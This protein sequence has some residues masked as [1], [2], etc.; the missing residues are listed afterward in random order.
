MTFIVQQQCSRIGVPYYNCWDMLGRQ[1]QLHCMQQLGL[2]RAVQT[3]IAVVTRYQTN[4][5]TCAYT[6]TSTS[7]S[8][9]IHTHTHTHMH[10][11]HTTRHRHTCTLSGRTPLKQISLNKID[12]SFIKMPHVQIVVRGAD[13]TQLQTLWRPLGMS[14]SLLA[15]STSSSSIICNYT[16][17]LGAWEQNPSLKLP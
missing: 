10:T 2:L 1:T 6:L 15:S 9:H 7:T 17:V 16:H 5:H 8:T 14:G 13:K 11:H 3:C 4:M 12:L